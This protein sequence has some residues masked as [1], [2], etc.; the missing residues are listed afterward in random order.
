MMGSQG[1]DDEEPKG[2]KWRFSGQLSNCEVLVEGRAPWSWLIVLNWRETFVTP[3]GKQRLRMLDDR[4]QRMVIGPEKEVPCR[5]L[6]VR[7]EWQRELWTAAD[8]DAS[9]LAG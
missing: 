9:N 7:N 8:T 2:L 6:A 5:C 3:G 1:K 4:V